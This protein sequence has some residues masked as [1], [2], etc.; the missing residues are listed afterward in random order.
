MNCNFVILGD[1]DWL[2]CIIYYKYFLIDKEVRVCYYEIKGESVQDMG[3]KSIF[4][5]R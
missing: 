3:R 4:F 5:I 1:W 2:Y